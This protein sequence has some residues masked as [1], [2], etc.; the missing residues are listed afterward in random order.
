MTAY[1]TS[2]QLDA[3]TRDK[4]VVL[5]TEN[6]PQRYSSFF[7]APDLIV[8]GSTGEPGSPGSRPEGVL[9]AAQSRLDLE[10]AINYTG[11]RRHDGEGMG[12]T[13]GVTPDDD[14]HV[15]C[16]HLFVPP[17]VR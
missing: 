17:V 16:E 5:V 14:I 2:K 13:V 11:R 15:V 9:I 3:I 10:L 12:I 7:V 1:V 4:R 6:E 8:S